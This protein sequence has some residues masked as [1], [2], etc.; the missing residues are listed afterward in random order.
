MKMNKKS[1]DVFWI[2]IEILMIIIGVVML[3]FS[4]KGIIDE[5]IKTRD[6][7]KAE[8]MFVGTDMEDVEGG[9][10]SLEY[11]YVVDGETYYVSTDYDT[12]IIPKEGSIKTIKYNPENP[13][14]A[15]I[16]GY[17][18]KSLIILLGVM[19][20]GIPLVILMIS[21]NK[22]DKSSKQFK[23]FKSFITSFFVS[24]VIFVI[25]LG[26]CYMMCLGTD[27][28]NIWEAFKISGG[29]I[30]LPLTFVIIG[31]YGMLASIFAKRVKEVIVKVDSI[32]ENEDGTYDV[33]LN[34]ESIKDESLGS[35]MY[36][37]FMYNTE[38]KDKFAV[39]KKFKV[40]I[41]KYGIAH[42]CVEV[43]QIVQ[44]RNLKQFVDEDFE[45]QL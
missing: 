24:F 10:H 32:S 4:I 22:K 2:I 20:V 35:L 39:D 37:Y 19:F 18:E 3:A 11:K 13:G 43:S 16:K 45:E 44:A 7:I 42:Q 31:V 15:V 21:N 1:E 36:K 25:G 38:N 9:T 17:G 29:L 12:S 33:I 30:V 41:Y 26:F 23:K 34:D 8:A 6:Y 28:F 40:N 27:G 14:D 5:N